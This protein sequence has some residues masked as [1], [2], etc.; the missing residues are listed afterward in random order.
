VNTGTKI[1]AFGVILVAVFA[2]ALAI[3]AV[4]GPIDVGAKAHGETMSVGVGGSA[5][6]REIARQGVSIA[7]GGFRFE[8]STVEI[9][10]DRVA[11]F[12]FRIVDEAGNAVLHFDVNHEREL[13]L[14]VVSRNLIDYAHVHPVRDGLGV[15]IVDLPSLPS[16]SYRVLAYFQPAGAQPA[17]LGADL[18][19]SGAPR[20]V[21]RPEPASTDRVERRRCDCPV[22]S[23][24]PQSA[25]CAVTASCIAF[26]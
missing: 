5:Q 7:A 23:R 24:S 8:P 22:S 21:Q 11:T 15:W 10:A 12:R 4:A 26:L 13:H 14:I 17:T 2:S 3:G 9:P 25:S 18:A 20:S 19:V 1:I 6:L 16:G